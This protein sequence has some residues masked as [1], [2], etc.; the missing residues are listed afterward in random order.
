MYLVNG[1]SVNGKGNSA[2]YRKGPNCGTNPDQRNPNLILLPETN[3]Y[4]AKE[5]G[6]VM[7]DSTPSWLA[8]PFKGS[9]S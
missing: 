1:L 6:E 7:G 9:S 5:L 4:V 8:K 3:R 2:P